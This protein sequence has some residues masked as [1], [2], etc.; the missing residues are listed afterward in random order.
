LRTTESCFL[1]CY[2]FTLRSA[3]RSLSLDP[4]LSSLPSLF[5]KNTACLTLSQPYS[6]PA[7]GSPT[8]VPFTAIKEPFASAHGSTFVNP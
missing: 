6:E 7:P 4:Y 2:S 1:Q 8:P 5:V 3:L